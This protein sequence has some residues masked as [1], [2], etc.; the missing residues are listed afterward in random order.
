MNALLKIVLLVTWLT[1]MAM[2]HAFTYGS[3]TEPEPVSHY[4]N[5][6]CEWTDVWNCEWR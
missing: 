5:Y 6:D 1:G 4:V 3:L 2:G